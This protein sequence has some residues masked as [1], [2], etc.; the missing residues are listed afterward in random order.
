MIIPPAILRV[1]VSCLTFS[2]CNCLSLLSLLPP[3]ANWALITA[4][5]ACS[6][7]ICY[8]NISSKT[9]NLTGSF[10]EKKRKKVKIKDC[11]LCYGQWSVH[12]L[13]T[14]EKNSSG[15]YPCLSIREVHKAIYQLFLRCFLTSFNNIS[16]GSWSYCVLVRM[17]GAQY[18]IF[19]VVVDCCWCSVQH[20][21]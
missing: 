13:L 17:L 6:F 3:T 5:C 14:L 19:E 2:L 15:I 20:G 10:H 7:T 16:G 11:P 12:S 9:R 8:S 4:A 18:W 21:T 1:V